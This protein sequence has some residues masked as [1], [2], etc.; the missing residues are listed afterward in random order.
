MNS[1][2]MLELRTIL[3]YVMYLV[4]CKSEI[5]GFLGP[6]NKDLKQILVNVLS[7]INVNIKYKQ[8][9]VHISINHGCLRN[10]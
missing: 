1:P 9:D 10:I 6:P 2:C 3:H 5:Q 8:Q 4:N 7:N